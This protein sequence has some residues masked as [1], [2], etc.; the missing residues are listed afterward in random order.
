METSLNFLPAKFCL[1]VMDDG[2]F[3]ETETEGRLSFLCSLNEATGCL[4]G[5]DGD[6]GRRYGSADGSAD[7]PRLPVTVVD[8]V[9][10]DGGGGVVEV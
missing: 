10:V 9:V 5:G 8:V 2:R 1:S 3:C 6:S 7:T 4:I